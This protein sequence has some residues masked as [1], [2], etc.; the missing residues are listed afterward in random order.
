MKKILIDGWLYSGISKNGNIMDR[1]DVKV[2]TGTTN[3][4]LLSLHRKE[5]VNLIIARL[6]APGMPCESLFDEIRNDGSLRTV[7]VILYCTDKNMARAERCAPNAIM[8]LPVNTALLLEKLHSF[9]NVST[10]GAYRVLTSISISA[11]GDNPFFC[12]SEN[13]SA[14][15][16]LLET[17]RDLAAGSRLNCAFFLPD[18]KRIEVACEIARVMDHPDKKGMK[19]YGVKFIKIS[20]SDAR[21]IEDFVKKKSDKA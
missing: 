16:M 18:A 7:S 4:E 13:I 2:Y 6:D 10:R 17:D 12:K 3:D 5:K 20:P 9:L 11:G 14:T 19:K 8:T 1:A 15:G 21:T